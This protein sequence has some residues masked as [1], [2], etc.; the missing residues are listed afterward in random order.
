[1]KDF[2][3]TEQYPD[4][5]KDEQGRL[6]VAAGIGFLGDAYNRASALMEAGVDVLV[7]DTANGEAK[8]A[9]D[10]IRRLKS[11]SAF[12]GVDIIGGNVATRQ[13]LRP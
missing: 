2:V 5:T 4:A 7:V 13:A 1:M 8:L 12:K 10:M 6:R 9:L 3:K 11:D